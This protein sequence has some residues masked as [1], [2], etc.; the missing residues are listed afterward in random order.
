MLSPIVDNKFSVKKYIQI[1]QLIFSG[2][3]I[4]QIVFLLITIYLVQFEGVRFNSSELNKLYQYAAPIMVIC[5]LPISF[6]IFRNQLKQLKRKSNV[7]EKLAEYQSAQILR[8]A[9]L[10]G[11][12]FFAIMV[13]FLTSN[14][15]YLCLV[16]ITMGTFVFTTPSRNRY[17]M[18]LKLTIEEKSK[19]AQ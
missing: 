8:W 1:C 3:I 4:G 15:L 2:L 14:Y 18:D 19:L 16:G 13:F 12:S 17:D 5:I 9:F 7:F 6:L 11:A 10:E